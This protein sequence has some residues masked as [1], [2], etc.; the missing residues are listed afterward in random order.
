MVRKR[1][2]VSLLLPLLLLSLLSAGCKKY[3]AHPGS[4]NTFDSKVY[5]A[6]VIYHDAIES[7]K[8]DYKASPPVFPESAVPILNKFIDAYNVLQGAWVTYHSSAGPNPDQTAVQSALNSAIAAFADLV[9]VY[10]KAS[11]PPSSGKPVA[12]ARSVK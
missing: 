3:Q 1:R 4:L 12:A 6:L 5:D 7:A 11:T 2:A 10:P 9:K 8:A